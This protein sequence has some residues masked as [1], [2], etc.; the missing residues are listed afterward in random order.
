MTSRIRPLLF[1]A[2]VCALHVTTMTG[3][4]RAQETIRLSPQDE[5]RWRRLAQASF[6]VGDIPNALEAWNRVGEPMLVR[7]DVV[8]DGRTRESVVRDLLGLRTRRML[9]PEAFTRA[10]R[11]LDDLPSAREVSLRYVALAN[12]HARV[13]ARIEEHRL[14]PRSPSTL[15]AILGRAIVNRELRAD[16]ANPTGSGE[17]IGLSWRNQEGWSRQGATLDVPAPGPLPGLLYVDVFSEDQGYALLP[18]VGIRRA[19]QRIGVGFSD[20]ATG[21]LHW[22]AG[23]AWDRFDERAYA[24]VDLGLERRLLSDHASASVT[25]SGWSPLTA[26]RAFGVGRAAIAFRTTTI[27]D[28]PLFMVTGGTTV[29]TDEAPAAVWPGA[30]ASQSRGALLRAHALRR[31]GWLVGEA[32][33]RTLT[34]GSSEYQ[35]PIRRFRL[36][37][38]LGAVF[39]DTVKASRR[40]ADLAS[41]P[42]LTD[43]GAGARLQ[44]SDGGLLRIDVARSLQDGKIRVSIGFLQKWPAR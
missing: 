31:E 43:V 39:V 37:T 18:E 16:V 22:T 21:S 27:P 44:V 12:G 35:H 24:G 2:L 7:V 15:A 9:T 20:W 28:K 38:V 34:Y 29:A 25:A 11:R 40:F 26:G 41:T 30:G 4:A 17:K 6:V 8:D 14:L 33:G 13:E 5:I 42:W 32:F 1:S 10:V 36:A 23:G 19:R 3:V